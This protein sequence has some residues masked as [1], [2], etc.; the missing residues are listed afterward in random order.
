MK[1]IEIPDI[2]EPTRVTW[3]IGDK[4]MTLIIDRDVESKELEVQYQSPTVR[5]G[6]NTEAETVGELVTAKQLSMIRYLAREGQVDADEVCR[7][8]V[9]CRTDS[10]SKRSA[11]KLIDVLKSIAESQHK[12]A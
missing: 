10:L 2:V 3:R 4:R 6:V 12:S 8:E 1:S 9:G 11:S 7:A 5:D